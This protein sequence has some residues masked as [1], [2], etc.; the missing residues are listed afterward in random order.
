M[1]ERPLKAILEKL[2]FYIRKQAVHLFSEQPVFILFSLP[3]NQT[4]HRLQIP[5]IQVYLQL[6]QY[7]QTSYPL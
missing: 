5:A 7:V 4:T 3:R 1:F 6:L 2:Y